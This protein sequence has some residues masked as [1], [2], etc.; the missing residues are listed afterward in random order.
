[1]VPLVAL[2]R[3]ETDLAAKA[4]LVL[5]QVTVKAGAAR[6]G[7]PLASRAATVTLKEVPL[8][9]VIFWVLLMTREKVGASGG[10]GVG[11]GLGDGAGLGLGL[12][13]GLGLGEGLGLG[14]GD[15]C[16]TVG[17]AGHST[18]RRYSPS[19]A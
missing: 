15:G 7:A 17:T 6:R 14:L 5:A 10:L 18:V 9:L 19:D 13:D 4:P 2:V 1:M 11:G 12:G 8:L 3:V 16:T